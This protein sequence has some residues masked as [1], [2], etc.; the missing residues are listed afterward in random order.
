M[1]LEADDLKK[2]GKVC[3]AS[4]TDKIDNRILVHFDGWDER[5]DYWVDIRSPY[6]HHIDWHHENG[7]NITPPPGKF[8]FHEPEIGFYLLVLYQPG[9][10]WNKGEFEWA[11]YIRLKSRR[12][13]KAI[14]PADQSLFATRQP[15]DFKPGM[16][17]E[18]VDRKNQ[19]LIRPATVVATDGY[20]IKVCF[21][22]WPNFYSFWIEDDSSDIHPMNWCKRTYHPIEFPPG[23]TR[24]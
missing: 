5:Y 20:E 11:K 8:I 7:Y 21:D 18:V 3:V 16:K 19:M 23:K 10:D 12:I 13:G 4:V 9:T 1:S 14:I 15:M 6:I 22:G 17:L 2:S 24:I